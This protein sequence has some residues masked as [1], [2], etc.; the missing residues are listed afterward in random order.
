MTIFEELRADHDK[1]REMIDQVLAT[2]GASEERDR[3]FLNLKKQLEDH[4]L[5]EERYFYVPL[6]TFD[7]TQEKARHSVAE[8]HELDELIEALSDAEQDSSAW[9]AHAK[10]LAHKLLHHLEEEEKEVFPNA[11][12]IL[13]DDEK[14]SLGADYR[15]EMDKRAAP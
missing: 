5:A 6:M 11:G 9:L 10:N 1:Q 7:A 2:S 8:H 13:G 12:K 14:S 4:A 15:K 3:L